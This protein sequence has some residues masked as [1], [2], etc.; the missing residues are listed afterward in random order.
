MHYIN[1]QCHAV[2]R[3]C[4]T[5]CLPVDTGTVRKKETDFGEFT[6]GSALTV[7]EPGY[8]QAK[9]LACQKPS[10]NGLGTKR[11]AT[12][13]KSGPIPKLVNL[14][15]ENWVRNRLKSYSVRLALDSSHLI[16]TN[17]WYVGWICSDG[18]FLWIV[19]LSAQSLMLYTVFKAGSNMK[20]GESITR[21]L[22][23]NPELTQS[24]TAYLF[25]DSTMWF[26]CHT[27]HMPCLSV[28]H[29]PSF[30]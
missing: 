2:C 26:R 21:V 30:S 11:H 28:L 13:L 5:F 22:K 16:L 4:C 7:Q 18:N 14:H 3:S 24:H 20:C 12:K 8:S 19:R 17:G 27:A 29:L 25:N 9:I 6:C 10:N 23:L 15:P 1:N